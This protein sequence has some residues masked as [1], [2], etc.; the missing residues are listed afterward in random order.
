MFLCG[1]TAVRVEF[2]PLIPTGP[3]YHSYECNIFG[4][5]MK[6]EHS[7]QILI[8][9]WHDPQLGNF[10]PYKTNQKARIPN[11]TAPPSKNPCVKSGKT[12]PNSLEHL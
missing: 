7:G 8:G 3:A 1:E 12:Y 2:L 11:F 9:C 10:L 4:A 6:R 5:S